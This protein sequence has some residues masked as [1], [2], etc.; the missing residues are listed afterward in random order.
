MS[1]DYGHFSVVEV[2]GQYY[3]TDLFYKALKFYNDM[4]LGVDDITIE[5]GSNDVLLGSQW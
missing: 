3:N 4:N 2:M 1:F 5:I